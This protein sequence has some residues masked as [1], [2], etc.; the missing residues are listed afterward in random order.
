MRAKVFQKLTATNQEAWLKA[1]KL[2][3]TG[4]DI[5]AIAGLSPWSTVAHIYMDKINPEIGELIT[6]EAM[7]E[8]QELEPWVADRWAKKN[9]RKIKRVNAILQHPDHP[10]AL[11]NIDR[12]VMNPEELLEIKTSGAGH[13][14]S[15][16][17]PPDY[18]LAQVYW[19]MFVTGLPK[20]HVA[21]YR[22][23]MG[24]FKL[25][26]WTIERDEETI[27][28]LA[29][30]GQQFWQCVQDRTPPAKIGNDIVPVNI[31]LVENIPTLDDELVPLAV[32]LKELSDKR[33]E[34]EKE[35]KQL[36][37]QFQAYMGDSEVLA[38]GDIRMTYK[39]STSTSLDQW[40]LKEK[41]PA[42][43]EECCTTK[44]QRRFS[45]K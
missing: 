41:Y 34:L 8:G 29:H 9:D 7:T 24:G 43:Y 19:Y 15:G 25:Q 30:L 23:G 17:L 3:V 14:W 35:E 12:L 6:N 42:I 28:M 40:V 18:V 4:T 32:Q 38:A 1:R 26:E 11:A 5:A 16:E 20:T 33:K 13:G 21:L 45:I 10:W 37:E 31:Q 39:P 36:K 27:E 2:G 22:G 44:T